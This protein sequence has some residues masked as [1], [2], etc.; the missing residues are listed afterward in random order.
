MKYSPLA[1]SISLALL[2]ASTQTIADDE[3]PIC[4]EQQCDEV[5]IISAEA[6]QSPL[7]TVTDPKKPRQPL[8]AFDGSGFLKTLP[9]FTVT[10]KGGSGGD[11]TLRGLG[12]SRINIV[13]D[14][15]QMGGT[16][17]GR[18]DPPTNYI[19][20]ETYEKVTIIKGPQTVKYGPVGSAGTVLF[21]RDHYG[22][23]EAGTEGRAS[24]TFGSFKRRDYL[25]ELTAGNT[26]HYWKLDVNGSKSDD[27]KDG[28]GREMQSEYDRQSVHAAIG[29]TP[30][31]DTV[32]ELSY[33]YSSGSAEYADRGNKARTIDNENVT[34]LAKTKLTHDIFKT[35][36]VQLYA[37]EN[38]HI[39]DRFDR[40][41]TDITMLPRGANPRRTNYGGH[42]WFDVELADNWSGIIG[43]DYLESTQD[44]RT[45]YSV[46]EIEAAPYIDLYSKENLGL[47][48]ESNHDVAA[49]TLYTGLRW[50]QWTTDLLEGWAAPTKEN[51][52]DEDLI[53]GFVRYEITEGDT[54]WI[55]GV[56][57]AE[58]I[59]DYWEVMKSG[60]MLT[61]APE[62]TDQIDLGWMYEGDVKVTAS[63]F[64][65]DIS[66]YILIDRNSRP[67][68]RNVDV[69]LWGGELSTEVELPYGLQW[70]TT[71]A[72][73]H[74]TNDT[75]DVA[76]GQVSPLEAKFAL[77]YEGNDWS[78][79]ALWRIADN[80]DRIAL[81]QGNI[82]NQDLGETAGFGVLSLNGAWKF[83][84]DIKVSF[85]LDNVLDKTYAE[86]VSK[87]GAG[88]DLLD[89]EERTFQV[90]EPGRSFWV[91][92]DY[93]F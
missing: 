47:F 31:K 93:Q 5:I 33:G 20:P 54:T 65:A 19:S 35:V 25:M 28:E 4:G 14:G 39:M 41:V 81:G 89:F 60:A 12:G 92:M 22:L 51:S 8:P 66:D 18:M 27:F 71:V 59:A 82:V 23:K 44:L 1:Q 63:V 85:G 67:N 64:Y 26:E 21:E 48:I 16:C 70:V 55:A 61:L 9:G 11:V 75:D 62:T 74:G 29:W 49:G 80:Q 76:L 7:T 86:H 52:R 46:D 88:N 10:R 73:S 91:K 90:N 32:V 36:E 87:S 2:L 53:S 78:F 56:G 6:M 3:A 17:G 72:Y 15:K 13:N 24:M 30:E 57:R 77:N 84:S 40:P 58:R 83:S 43:V 45:G 34:L 68:A 37:N 38:D 69:T 50:D 79:G 42:L